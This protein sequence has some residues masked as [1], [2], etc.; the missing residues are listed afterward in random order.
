MRNNT[1]I[2]SSAGQQLGPDGRSRSSVN[3]SN[4]PGGVINHPCEILALDRFVQFRMS[5]EYLQQLQNKL[6]KLGVLV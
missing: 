5:P 1:S 2:L 4:A 3:R 6:R